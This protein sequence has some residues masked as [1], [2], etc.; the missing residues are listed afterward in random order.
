M[1]FRYCDIQIVLIDA[2]FLTTTL[3]STFSLCI[4]ILFDKC[5]KEANIFQKICIEKNKTHYNDVCLIVFE[6]LAVK[7]EM[8]TEKKA[9]KKPVY[10]VLRTCTK[11]KDT[12]LMILK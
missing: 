12:L 1:I 10:Y 7:M 6:R 11:N 5:K 3:N 9:K 8:L 4:F 2:F